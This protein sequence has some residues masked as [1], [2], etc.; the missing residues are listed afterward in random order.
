MTPQERCDAAR[1]RAGQLV[2]VAPE[3]ETK[4]RALA[5]AARADLIV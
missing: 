2:R 5:V 4:W 3:E 1:D